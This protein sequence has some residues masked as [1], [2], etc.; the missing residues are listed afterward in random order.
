VAN[1]E[2]RSVPPGFFFADVLAPVP[3]QALSFAKVLPADWYMRTFLPEA[4]EQGI[5]FC[6]GTIA[7]SVVGGGR[8]DAFARGAA[9]GIL[10]GAL[11]GFVAR[12]RPGPW[13]FIFYVWLTVLAYNS[14]RMST[15]HLLVRTVYDFLPVVLGVK[16][17]AWS[18]GLA[19]RGTPAIPA[20]TAV[21]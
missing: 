13:W 16:G 9:L 21:L 7:E 2:I 15:F 20:T 10:F 3:Q 4:A 17:V 6:F 12:R 5:N 1:G 18:L 11:H 19:R 14:F 8:A